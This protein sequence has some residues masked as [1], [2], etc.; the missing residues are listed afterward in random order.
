MKP[1]YVAGLVL[2]ALAL[3]L[4]LLGMLLADTKALRL[5]RA[6]AYCRLATALVLLGAYALTHF[7]WPGVHLRQVDFWSLMVILGIGAY[8]MIW[9][10]VAYQFNKGGHEDFGNSFMLSM[11]Y[12]DSEHARSHTAADTKPA[13]PETD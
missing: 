5:R 6:P 13:Q 9:A 3:V 10:A 4:A 12:R 1:I 7:D 11:L 2:L 8:T